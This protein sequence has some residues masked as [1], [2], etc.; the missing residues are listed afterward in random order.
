MPPNTAPAPTLRTPTVSPSVE[1]V[2][3]KRKSW[4]PKAVGIGL[5][6]LAVGLFIFAPQLFF[7]ALLG[8]G[9]GVAQLVSKPSIS[10][11]FVA[12]YRDIQAKF[13][14]AEQRQKARSGNGEF[15]RLKASL[16]ALKKEYHELPTEEKRRIDAHS[17][18]RREEQLNAHL[19]RF[20][21]RHYK[22]SQIGPAI[23]SLAVV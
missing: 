2:A 12:K 15:L 20:Q 6:V 18:N 7:F 4:K 16:S 1:A 17:A 22:I 8:G 5:L 10:N 11:E 3:E 9:I 21:I 23:V 13:F 14:E 19:D